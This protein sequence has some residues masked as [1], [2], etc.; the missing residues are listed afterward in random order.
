MTQQRA[1]S[2]DEEGKKGKRMRYDQMILLVVLE[3]AESK[4]KKILNGD[5]TTLTWQSGS[6]DAGNPP[7][8]RQ[9]DKGTQTQQDHNTKNRS[10]HAR[11]L[12]WSFDWSNSWNSLKPVERCKKVQH[13]RV[14]ILS[15]DVPRQITLACTVS[16]FAIKPRRKTCHGQKPVERPLFRGG[17]VSDVTSTVS[18]PIIIYSHMTYLVA[19]Y[20]PW[21][22]SKNPWLRYTQQDFKPF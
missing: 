6:R 7:P 2:S 18:P 20:L 14:N 5:Q 4:M 21:S 11:I 8:C 16:L 9:R 22:M 12:A 1:S 17:E 15:L 19:T 3:Q 10:R 13:A